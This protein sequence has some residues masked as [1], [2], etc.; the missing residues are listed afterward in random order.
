MVLFPVTTRSEKS[1]SRAHRHDLRA[2]RSWWPG[3]TYR[4]LS[5]TF[6]TLGACCL[7]SAPWQRGRT[8]WRSEIGL[9]RVVRD[10]VLVG[11]QGECVEI[12]SFRHICDDPTT[13]LRAVAFAPS[14]G[15]VDD[16]HSA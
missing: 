11:L 6:R 4:C 14:S 2:D 16:A 12:E 10:F 9:L 5:L 1:F 7:R 8:C 13:M 3:G 15:F